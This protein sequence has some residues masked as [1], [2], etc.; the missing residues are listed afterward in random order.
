M[1]P[2]Q[3]A[4]AA[5][6]AAMPD[7]VRELA[8]A[9]TRS[10]Q[11]RVAQQLGRSAALVSQILRNRYAAETTAVEELVRGALM[12][13]TVTCPALGTIPTNVCQDWRRRS[14]EFVTGN[15]LR[16]RMYRACMVCPRNRR[17]EEAGGPVSDTKADTQHGTDPGAQGR[18]E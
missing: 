9:C 1:T 4:E 10:S 7:W 3:V 17:D 8:L 18:H 15:P 13:A 16:L 6:G 2:L 14:R 12:N 5:W 11:N